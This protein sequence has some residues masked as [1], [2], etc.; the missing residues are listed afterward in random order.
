M[1][2]DVLNDLAENEIRVRKGQQSVFVHIKGFL[3]LLLMLNKSK[4]L[5]EGKHEY[6]LQI[7]QIYKCTSISCI[8]P[9]NNRLSN[10]QSLSSSQTS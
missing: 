5:V 8:L 10:Y 1:L 7:Y 6:I 3:Q 4:A 2:E 9:S